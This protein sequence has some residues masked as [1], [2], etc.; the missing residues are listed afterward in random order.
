[1]KNTPLISIITPTYNRAHTLVECIESVLNQCYPHFEWWIIDDGSAD[2][3]ATIINQYEDERIKY[4]PLG[5]HT[6]SLSYLRNLGVSKAKGTY[7]SFID[8]DD[9]WLPQ[10]LTEQIHAIQQHS[11]A[12]WAFCD[13]IEFNQTAMLRD[14][15]YQRLNRTNG[16]YPNLF[17]DLIHGQLIIFPSS[18]LIHRTAFAEVGQFDESLPLS[19]QAFLIRLAKQCTA[20]FSNAK[21]VK[22]RKH[23]QNMSHQP[24]I[25]ESG[26]LEIIQQL[27]AA[28]Q[29]RLVSSD[30]YQQR[31]AQLLFGL[32]K[33]YQHS[34]Q[35]QQA[36]NT[37]QQAQ[38]YS[39][40]PSKLWLKIAL[41]YCWTCIHPK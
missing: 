2:D 8:S 13:V 19:D 31:K 23:D 16:V 24:K 37:Y 32:G 18:V 9:C 21:L 20:Y 35:Y 11:T 7:I 41:H 33:V 27:E 38:K 29:S 30:F 39:S 36:L 15:I 1:M 5:K 3:T 17:T 26:H 14:G 10:K 28:Y 4:Y 34:R 40:F 12:K 22:I 6:G 25:Q